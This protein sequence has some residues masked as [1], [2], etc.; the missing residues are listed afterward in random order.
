MRAGKI[1]W[2]IVNYLSL[3]ALLLSAGCVTKKRLPV[4]TEILSWKSVDYAQDTRPR[5]RHEAAFV[6]VKNNFYLLG[7]RRIQHV[8]IFDPETQIWT[9]GAQPPLELHHF[10]PIVYEGKIYIIAAM[11]GPYPGETPVPNFYSYDPKTNTWAKGP[12]IPEDRRRG[13][14]G[15]VLDG[16][17]VYLSSGIQDGHRNGHVTWLDS[18][19]FK[20]GAWKTYPDAPRARDHFQSALVDGKIYNLGGR[21][22]KAPRNTFN[23]TEGKIDYFDLEQNK[24]FTVPE[25]LPTQRAG[26]F[27]IVLGDDIVVLGGES[28]DQPTAHNEVEAFNV[29]DQNW[30]VLPRFIEGR[31]GTGIVYYKGSLYTVSGSGRK[32]GKPELLTMERLDLQKMP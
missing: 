1:E 29:K 8:S 17:T 4:S 11:T 6:K 20:T 18:Y 2:R 25:E 27:T 31:H 21:R 28:G 10:Q 5:A 3:F 15:I 9:E 13:S 16:D 22:S 12:E 32:G 14:A 7:G 23:D 26:I 19:N 24:W 30:R